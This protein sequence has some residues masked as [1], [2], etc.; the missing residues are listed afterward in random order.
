MDKQAREYLPGKVFYCPAL[1]E[2]VKY[3]MR[4]HRYI[5]DSIK[6]IPE[7]DRE[8]IN[9]DALFIQ[10]MRG[11]SVKVRVKVI[12]RYK[13]GMLGVVHAQARNDRVLAEMKVLDA[14]V[15]R[16]AQNLVTV[17]E[18][19]EVY[20]GQGLV[21]LQTAF[22]DALSADPAITQMGLIIDDAVIYTELDPDYVAQINAKIVAE[23]KEMAQGQV[24][25]ANLAE[26]K[27]QKAFAEIEKNKIV[28]AAEAAKEKEILGAEAAN[29]QVILKA[30]A[31]KQQV[32]LAAEADMEKER[33]EGEGLKLR[34]IAESEGVLAL[35][36]AEAKGADALKLAKY[37]GEAGQ[38]QTSV[39]IATAVAEKVAGMFKGVQVIP[40]NAFVSVGNELSS[41]AKIQPVVEVG[42]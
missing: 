38:R 11:Q 5:L 2:V 25:L 36:L 23:Q 26:A 21:D 10:V 20:T 8:E 31:D 27:A 32:V 9:G 22:K 42:K 30:E 39:L 28:V 13:P 17:K 29:Q 12:W 3:D 33:M 19:L 24:E 7:D 41:T 37:D 1:D 34:K 15:R 4:K 6:N 18:A 14:P 16:I 35:A 40:E